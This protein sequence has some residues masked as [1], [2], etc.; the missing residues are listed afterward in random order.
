MKTKTKYKTSTIKNA[1]FIDSETLYNRFVD[2][3]SPLVKIHD[4]VDFSFVNDLCDGIYSEDGQNAYLPEL[5]FKVSFIQFYKGGLSDNEVVK[6]CKTN[7]EYRYFCDLA[8]DDGLFDDCKLSRFRGELGQKKFKEIFDKVVEKIK[9]AGLIDEN[10]VQY[11]DSFLL[12]ADVKLIS[13]NALI[14]KAIQQALK[15]LD[16]TDSKTE[17]DAKK[18]DFE[19]SEDE[20]KKRFV[21]LIQKAQDILAFAKN[22]NLSPE[23]VKALALLRRIVKER[24]EI[25][26][27]KI[28]KK[29]A[30]EEKDKIISVSDEDARMMGKKE[31]DIA[32]SYKSHTAM[33][34]RGFI[35]Y[36][37]ATVA[38]VYD[39][40]HAFTI[41]RDLKSRGFTVPV[42]VGDTHYGDIDFREKMSL[43]GT[44]VVAPYRENQ[45]MNSCLTEDV[46][47]EAWA[48]NH[49]DEYREH[50]RIR[51]HIEP[52]QGEMKNLH[53]MRRARF[54]GLEKVMIQNYMSAIVTNCKL[55]KAS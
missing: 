27:D 8:I 7:M 2:S 29:E 13:I 22:K 38:T 37:G 9:D 1:K 34:F 32:P 44:Q 23:A 4:G 15:S 25:K 55:W 11:M 10:D 6:Q 49:T 35:T 5:V 30:V 43:Q 48:Y 24:A 14:S 50:R 17:E 47:I 19:L 21:F 40:H 20:Q 54:R 41:V 45:V 18:R 31:N 12:L 53:G 42:A 46:M 39:G 33:N 28:R 16:R 26:E 36:T 52:K 51:S 3:N